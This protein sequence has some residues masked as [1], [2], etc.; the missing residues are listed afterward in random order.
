[1][2]KLTLTI[3]AFPWPAIANMQFSALLIIGKVSVIRLG[4]GLGE[5]VIGAIQTEVSSSKRWPGNKEQVCPSGPMPRSSASNRGRL[6]GEK[7]GAIF[8]I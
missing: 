1:M 3:S 2:N 8:R 5:L 6:S 7:N 4:G